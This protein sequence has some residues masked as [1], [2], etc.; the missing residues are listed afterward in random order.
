MSVHPA[1]REVYTWL[2]FFMISGF[3]LVCALALSAVLAALTALSSWLAGRLGGDLRFAKRFVEHAYAYMP[4]AMISLVIGLGGELFDALPL[5]GAPASLIP[6][7]KAALFA[8]GVAWS[9]VIGWRL[10]GEQGLG[11][12]RRLT[13]LTPLVA[14]IGIVALAW[15][16][17]IFGL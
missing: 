7:S 12:G 2:D 17:A 1:G 3:M 11:G 8:A 9:L 6:L 13:S 15:W 14:G 16:P 4:V 10:L 5:A